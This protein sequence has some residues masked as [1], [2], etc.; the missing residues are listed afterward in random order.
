MITLSV[1]V[2]RLNVSKFDRHK[3]KTLAQG[4][5][6]LLVADL[7]YIDRLDSIVI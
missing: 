5:T 1:Q 3:R 7:E 6:D 2:Y 4:L